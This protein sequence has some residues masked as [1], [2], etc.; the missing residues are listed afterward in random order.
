[1]QWRVILYGSALLFLVFG[2]LVLG[3]QEFAHAGRIEIDSRR[4]RFTFRPDLNDRW[5]QQYPQAVYHLV[6]S[7]PERVEAIGGDELLYADGKRRSGAFAAI[8]TRP[9]D[10]FVFAVVGSMT[11]PEQAEA[12][13]S[14]YA[15]PVAEP[16]MLAPS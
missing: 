3:E 7:T 14:K 10:E 2:H 1:M 9:T 15:E 13:A 4:K 5:G 8:R 12:L 16:S 11:D 6:T